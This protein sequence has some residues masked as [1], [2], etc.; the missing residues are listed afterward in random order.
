MQ[1]AEQMTPAERATFI[2]SMVDRLAARLKDQPNDLGG[3]LKLARAYTVLNQP[4][5]AQEA[6]AKAA[7]L[8]PGPLDVQLDYANAL[9]TG[10]GDTDRYLPPAFI[11]TVKRVRT[12][13]PNNPLGLYYGGMVERVAGN[14]DAARGLWQQVLALLPDGSE[15][16]AAMQR[17]IDGLESKKPN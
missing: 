16:R 5:Q 14:T 8:A 12:L 2:Q 6:W 3:W 9:I 1:A 17:E 10:R 7:A 13:A 11:E 4:S 15:Q